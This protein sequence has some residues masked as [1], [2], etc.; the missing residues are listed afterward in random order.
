M[1]V[2]KFFFA[3]S[4]FDFHWPTQKLFEQNGRNRVDLNDRLCN[5]PKRDRIRC[6]RD[7]SVCKLSRSE[8]RALNSTIFS[9]RTIRVRPLERRPTALVLVHLY[10]LP[11]IQMTLK[12]ICKDI[13]EPEKQN[14]LIFNLIF[15]QRRRK[16]FNDFNRTS[17]IS[18]FHIT[19]TIR[20]GLSTSF[21]RSYNQ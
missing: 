14:R 6:F 19:R 9:R 20:S 12:L 7:E 11:L 5:I 1:K 16:D 4:T 13:R 18:D 3:T 8:L 10:S 15:F 2:R 17:R 21:V